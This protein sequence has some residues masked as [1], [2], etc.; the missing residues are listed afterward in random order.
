VDTTLSGSVS[1][2][3]KIY[4]REP[5]LPLPDEPEDEP[6]PEPDERLLPLGAV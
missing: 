6:E 4:F 1:I 2:L 3:G 5:L